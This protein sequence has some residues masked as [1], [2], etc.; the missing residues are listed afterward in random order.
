MPESGGEGLICL[1]PTALYERGISVLGR[2]SLSPVCAK[3]TWENGNRGQGWPWVP[4]PG[5]SPEEWLK[6]KKKFKEKKYILNLMLFFFF[7]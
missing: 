3:L 1:S 2:I 5:V 6:K 4:L 7:F